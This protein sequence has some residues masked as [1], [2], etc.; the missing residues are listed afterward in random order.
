EICGKTRH[1]NYPAADRLRVPVHARGAQGQQPFP[2][3]DDLPMTLVL[4]RSFFETDPLT[5]ARA[6]IGVRLLVDGVGGIITETECYTPDD[7][8]S[9]SYRG[10]TK[11]NAAMFGPRG[12]A[13]VYRVMGLHWCFNVV[14]GTRAGE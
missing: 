7:P 3:N 11:R 1:S 6:L 13:Y 12:H 4:F 14:C 10:P 8:A 2:Q 9:H 5:L